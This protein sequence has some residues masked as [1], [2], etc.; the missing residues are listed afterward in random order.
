MSIVRSQP[1]P[2]GYL[3]REKHIEHHL[4]VPKEKKKCRCTE[5]SNRQPSYQ[6]DDNH[7][8]SCRTKENS[9]F[10]GTKEKSADPKSVR[11]SRKGVTP[12][13][14]VPATCSHSGACDRELRVQRTLTVVEEIDESVCSE[15]QILASAQQFCITSKAKPQGLSCQ[16][17]RLYIISSRTAKQ[18]LVA[19]EDSS[20]LC[21]QLCGPA[22]SCCLQLCDQ[23]REKVLRFCRPYRVDVCCLFCCLMVIR[24]FSSSN[25][26]LGFVQQRW[27]LFSP[28]LSVHDSEGRKTMDIQ[29]PWSA[30]RC[31]ADQEFQVTSV[32]GHKIAMIWKRWPGYNEDYN[33]D[34]DFFGLDISASITPTGKALLLSATFLLNYMFFE[35]S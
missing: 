27:S 21:H 1:S 26:L 19:I 24:V 29:G 33:I 30:A 32:D 31:H 15:L 5:I 4:K 35:M 2:F 14:S 11:S 16:S 13:T 22:R 12:I 23:S 7:R 34:H 28:S 6:K 9:L 17:K 18:L 20:C 10:Y 8:H 3:Q 25:V